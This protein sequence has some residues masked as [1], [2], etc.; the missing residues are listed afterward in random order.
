M[1][2]QRYGTLPIVRATGGLV[3]TVRDNETGFMFEDASPEALLGAIQRAREAYALD[4]FDEMRARCMNLDW[5]WRVSAQ[6]YEGVYRYAIG[7][8]AG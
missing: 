3:D 2:A 7:A 6:R 4:D 5:S 8:S 1:I